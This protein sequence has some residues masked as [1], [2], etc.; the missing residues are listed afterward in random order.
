M[1]RRI[2]QLALVVATAVAVVGLFSFHAQAIAEP[3]YSL[4]DPGRT[5]AATAW[6]LGLLLVAYMAGLPDAV[7]TLGRAIGASFAA[8]AATVAAASRTRRRFAGWINIA[9]LL[10]CNKTESKTKTGGYCTRVR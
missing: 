6:T 3:R 1:R 4:G 7:R 10:L 5:A 9:I 2:G 8:P